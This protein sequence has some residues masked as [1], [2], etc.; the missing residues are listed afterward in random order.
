MKSKASTKD[1]SKVN[2]SPVPIIP[3]TEKVLPTSTTLTKDAPSTV[4]Q[5][6][7]EVTALPAE[8][9]VA[10]PTPT[11]AAAAIVKTAAVATVTAAASPKQR[12]VLID[13]SSKAPALSEDSSVTG[14]LLDTAPVTLNASIVLEQ[15]EKLLKKLLKVLHVCARYQRCSGKQLPDTIDFFGKTLLGMTSIR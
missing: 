11:S 6:A 3:Q 9:H 14:K 2:L 7:G 1:D 5:T 15:S 4:S 10:D 13:L 8:G 12:K